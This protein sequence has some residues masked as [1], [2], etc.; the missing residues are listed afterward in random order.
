MITKSF[1]VS[2]RRCQMQTVFGQTKRLHG[3]VKHT[4]IS[5]GNSNQAQCFQFHK[6]PLAREQ[7]WRAYGCMIIQK[8]HSH[9]SA[10]SHLWL[11]SN[12]SRMEICFSSSFSR[13]YRKFLSRKFI[14]FGRSTAQIHSFLQVP[15]L[16]FTTSIQLN[17]Y[18]F[19]QFWPSHLRIFQILYGI[20]NN[21]IL[22]LPP[23]YAS[24]VVELFLSNG[25]INKYRL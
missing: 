17:L 13:A 2:R 15:N 24:E 18:E 14:I 23:P 22:Y 3:H 7:S 25:N 1:R 8:I 21:F 20:F 16:D 19:N 9:N 10:I 12:E 4:Q 11:A 6:L 5:N